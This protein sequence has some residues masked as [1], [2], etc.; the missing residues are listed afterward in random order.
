MLADDVACN[1]RNPHP[2]TVFNDAS[3]HINVYGENV[4]V[5]YRGSDVN[6]ENIIRVLTGRHSP[7]VPRSKRLAT[8]DRSNIL[9]FM[10]GK[11]VE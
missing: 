8:D 7:E 1:A 3:H 10:T 6:V 5:D 11:S 2:G 9:V 4:E